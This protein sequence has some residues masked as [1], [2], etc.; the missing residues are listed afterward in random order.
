MSDE[1]KPP[2][3]DVEN[4]KARLMALDG[5]A[6]RNTSELSHDDIRR[7]ILK[8]ERLEA[9]LAAVTKERD[10]N[11]RA[12]DDH[13]IIE[14]DQALAELARVRDDMRL[15]KYADKC[16]ELEQA[17]AELERTKEAYSRARF[18]SG[19]HALLTAMQERDE[20]RVELAQ[21]QA[22][23][24]VTDKMRL[25]EIERL[26]A[27]LEQLTARVEQYAMAGCIEAFDSENRP[28]LSDSVDTAR[29]A[30]KGDK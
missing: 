9:E 20:A 19:N 3:F 6:A 12:I 30:L 5:V 16:A 11:Q 21:A 10:E 28:N 2:P 15:T 25:V 7:L 14:R 17:R 24:D 13:L 1:Q 18:T 27:A 4:L 8:N 23:Y 22:S 26:R 29:A